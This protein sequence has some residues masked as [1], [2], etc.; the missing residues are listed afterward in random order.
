MDRI[1]RRRFRRNKVSA[2]VERSN[3]IA[4]LVVGYTC[5]K[6]YDSTYTLSMEFPIHC[7]LRVPDRVSDFIEHTASQDRIR[8]KP[9]HQILSIEIRASYDRSRELIMLVVARGNVSA[10]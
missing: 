1:P 10:L 8:R 4:A 3:F 5:A 6:R 9:Q 2:L 7:H